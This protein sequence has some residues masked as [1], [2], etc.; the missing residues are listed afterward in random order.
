MADESVRIKNFL[1][2]RMCSNFLKP[3]I[4]AKSSPLWAGYLDCAAS[5]DFEKHPIN[6]SFPPCVWD[7]TPPAATPE[8]S[9]SKI[10]G[11]G[12]L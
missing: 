9:V 8:K 1:A 11:S 7:K 4:T 2:L 6:F 5:R 12:E 3:R 10:K